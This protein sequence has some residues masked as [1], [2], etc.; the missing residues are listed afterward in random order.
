MMNQG[1]MARAD[2]AQLE[3]QLS[4]AQYSVTNTETMLANYKRQLKALLELDLNT[5]FDVAGDIPTDEQVL[6]VVPSAQEAYAKALEV[7]PEI[8]SAELGIEA[9]DMQ[10]DIA[11]R[12]FLPTIGVSAGLGSNHTS[13]S[14]DKWGKQMKTNLNMS[15]GVN[16]SVPIF[17][18]RRNMSN[19]KSAKLQQLSS[20]LEL[21]DKKNALSSTI[22][23]YWLDANNGQQNYIAAKAR[24]KSQEASYELLNEQFQNG[25][26][27]TVDVLQGRDNVISAAQDLL[28]SKYMALLNIQ[29]LK[30]YTG[31]KIEL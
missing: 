4:S 3:A 27:N 6:A 31:E 8:K 17:D 24:V 11:R 7:R 22:E 28:Q 21:Q 26:K 29:L 13:G 14:S 16:V 2:I 20:K 25:L 1:Q 18:N 15:A 5:A 30:F 10:L 23:Q 12:G 19:V 9:A